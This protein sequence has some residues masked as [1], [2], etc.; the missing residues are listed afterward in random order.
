MTSVEFLEER[1]QMYLSWYEGHHS[2]KEYKLEDFAKDFQEAKE[3]HKQEIINTWYNGYIN[4]SPMIDEENCGE[5]FYNETFG[6]DITLQ[7]NSESKDIT[8]LSEHSWEGCDGCTEQDEVMYKN[9]YV[10]GYNAAIA[11]QLKNK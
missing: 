9:G 2:A 3:M 8:E 6:Q 1:F 4:Q 11:E 10:K 5:Q 7:N